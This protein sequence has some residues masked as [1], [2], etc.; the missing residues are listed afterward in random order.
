MK[1]LW[2]ELFVKKINKVA[3]GL[4]LSDIVGVSPSNMNLHKRPGNYD[5]M[6][7][8]QNQKDKILGRT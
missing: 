1:S 4:G 3:W 5:T 7:K 8:L 2:L 6:V